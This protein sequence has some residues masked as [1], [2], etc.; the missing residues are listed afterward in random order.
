MIKII[1]GCK[2]GPRGGYTC[3]FV[4]EQE[5][6]SWN[7]SKAWLL[8]CPRYFLAQRGEIKETSELLL[9]FSQPGP[10]RDLQVEKAKAEGMSQGPAL[11]VPPPAHL[12][13]AQGAR[14]SF[15]NSGEPVCT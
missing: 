8:L 5:D 11:L 4:A 6:Q 12:W 14:L 1:T 3:P 15:L 9:P 7:A 13:T 10:G 2:N